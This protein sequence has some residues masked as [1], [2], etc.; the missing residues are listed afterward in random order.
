MSLL[1]M[2]S[3]NN[4]LIPRSSPP[5]VACKTGGRKCLGKRLGYQMYVSVQRN[6]NYN[7]GMGSSWVGCT[8]S[9]SLLLLNAH[10]LETG[11]SLIRSLMGQSHLLRKAHLL[12]TTR[13]LVWC[14]HSVSLQWGS[15]YSCRQQI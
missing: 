4:S 9:V 2:V 12:E 10:L 6:N 15:S 8:H 14:T 11:L 3:H 5:T 7:L 13:S 1:S